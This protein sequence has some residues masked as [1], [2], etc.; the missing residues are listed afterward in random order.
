MNDHTGKMANQGCKSI[1]DDITGLVEDSSGHVK[2]NYDVSRKVL[3]GKYLI[4][5]T[6]G[7]GRYAK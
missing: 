2:L 7:E 3:D 1:I 6:I 5:K 4:Q